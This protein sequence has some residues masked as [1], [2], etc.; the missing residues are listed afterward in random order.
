MWK[1]T[2]GNKNKQQPKK[3]IGAEGFD[4]F[5]TELFGSRWPL[6]KQSLCG[7]TRYVKLSPGGQESY[8]LDPASVC[9]ALCLP[10]AEAAEVL[11]LCAAP[12]GKTLAL[13]SCMNRN[14]R[15]FS[16]ERSPE[17]KGRLAHVIQTCLPEEI[18]ARITASCSDGATWCT[19]ESD[20]YDCILLDAP[21]SSE[22]HVLTD[23]KYLKQWSP[24]RIKSLAMEQWALLSSAYRLLA[25]GGYLVYATCAL[26]P[27]EDDD[28]VCRLLKKFP[29]A[30]IVDAEERNQI[31]LRNLAVLDPFV[32]DVPP[33][34]PVA[35]V[36][37][38]PGQAMTAAVQQLSLKDLY[39]LAEPTVYG[40]R[41]FPDKCDCAGPIYFSLV[42]KKTT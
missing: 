3:M 42:Q 39:G 27:Q 35:C 13:A 18:A 15:L 21:C 25:S 10:V 26:S 38:G 40:L 7:G 29:G 22:R 31:F 20:R 28:I 12:G 37:S 32:H 30:R 1:A 4:L 14:T 36:E 6:L 24:S 41:I 11:D 8:F 23:E 33:E 17:R 2:M 34:Q 16:N 19:R 5:Y 9:A